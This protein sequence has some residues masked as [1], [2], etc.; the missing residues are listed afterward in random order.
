[1][2]ANKSL[3]RHPTATDPKDMV[4]TADATQQT[5]RKGKWGIGIEPTLVS[6]V[7]YCPCLVIVAYCRSCRRCVVIS[8]VAKRLYTYSS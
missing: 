7:V 5:R 4:R 6:M 1:M 3:Q 8:L 2:N